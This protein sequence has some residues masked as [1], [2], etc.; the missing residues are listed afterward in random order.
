MAGIVRAAKL[1]EKRPPRHF[2]CQRRLDPEHP[3]GMVRYASRL[4]QTS[5]AG[6]THGSLQAIPKGYAT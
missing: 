4:D 1:V 2:I 6:N 3:R 5:H